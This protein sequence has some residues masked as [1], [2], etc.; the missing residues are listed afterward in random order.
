MVGVR[1]SGH[2][3]DHGQSGSRVGG[4]HDGGDLVHRPVSCLHIL[5]VQRSTVPGW[6]S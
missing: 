1:V 2:G 5:H 3:H 6:R 4:F